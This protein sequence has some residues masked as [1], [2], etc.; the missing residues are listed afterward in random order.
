[1]LA[2]EQ[3]GAR[4]AR[5]RRISL[6][7]AHPSCTTWE[8]SETA[9]G[10]PLPFVVLDWP[11]GLTLRQL[12]QPGAAA[13]SSAAFP[14]SI[15]ALWRV[16]EPTR[17]SAARHRARAPASCTA[18]SR[19]DRVQLFRDRRGGDGVGRATLLVLRRRARRS[20]RPT[21]ERRGQRRRRTTC[22]RSP[23][24]LSQVIARSCG[25]GRAAR[26]QR[27]CARACAV[28]VADDDLEAGVR[29]RAID[30]RST[31]HSFVTVGDS[32]ER[33]PAARSVS[34]IL[35]P[36]RALEAT[37]PARGAVGAVVV[38]VLVADRAVDHA[39]PPTRAAVTTRG[40]SPYALGGSPSLRSPW[41]WARSPGRRR[42]RSGPSRTGER[43]LPSC[44]RRSRRCLAP[45]ASDGAACPR[46][47][48]RHRGGD[49]A[50]SRATG[51]TQTI[52]RT[53]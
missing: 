27:R 26:R 25:A 52:P 28:V 15:D 46:G 1:M 6:A 18:G 23:A 41:V 24:I 42:A 20:A 45:P 29:A 34:W 14:E 40:R 48:D 32:L 4:R 31:G 53:T 51:T 35:A 22:A 39:A 12:V 2:R 50:R 9:A 10:K 36:L 43:G 13:G 38:L 21:L 49:A 44:R 17:R 3:E 8:W 7:G 30:P 11:H 33:A 37:T 19:R 16:L 47:D 5:A